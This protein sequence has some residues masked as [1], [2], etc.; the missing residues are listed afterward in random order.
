MAIPS[1]GTRMGKRGRDSYGKEGQLGR[2]GLGS[3]LLCSQEGSDSGHCLESHGSP[4]HL[5]T[6]RLV[7]EEESW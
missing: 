4:E 5:G 1:S 7:D 3:L 2:I 6:G